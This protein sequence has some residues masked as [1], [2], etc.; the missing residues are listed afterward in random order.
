MSD[1]TM[2]R[3]QGYRGWEAPCPPI[4]KSFHILIVH[5]SHICKEA[6]CPCCGK[7]PQWV[8]VI[9]FNNPHPNDM[10]HV[11]LWQ[12]LNLLPHSIA[13]SRHFIFGVVNYGT[14]TGWRNAQWNCN[15]TTCMSGKSP[16][17]LR[18]KGIKLAGAVQ[19]K[20]D[21]EGKS[22]KAAEITLALC[23]FATAWEKNTL[24][25]PSLTRNLTEAGADCN[26]VFFCCSLWTSTI[27]L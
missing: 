24:H 6:Q 1:I 12:A 3:Q 25:A 4:P 27:L 9:P 16:I 18:P 15:R 5:L 19:P 7:T 2:V 11:C 23:I 22:I 8:R 26:G 21:S 17:T 13:L 10:G 14:G 20:R